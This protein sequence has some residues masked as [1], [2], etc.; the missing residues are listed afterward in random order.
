MQHE[1][2]SKVAVSTYL[3]DQGD[4]QVSYGSYRVGGNQG[5]ENQGHGTLTRPPKTVNFD[6]GD[7]NYVD[8]LRRNAYTPSEY[9]LCL[10]FTKLCFLFYCKISN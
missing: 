1:D 5:L 9:N 6:M 7:D 3:I 8:T 10:I 4:G 2:A